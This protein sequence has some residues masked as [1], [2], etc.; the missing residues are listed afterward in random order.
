MT[1]NGFIALLIGLLTLAGAVNVGGLL[2]L[3]RQSR[4]NRE[5]IKA[6]ATR[7]RFCEAV[8]ARLQRESIQT[9]V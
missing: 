9:E 7:V 3:M 4:R 6:L 5:L 1:P 8:V 2:W